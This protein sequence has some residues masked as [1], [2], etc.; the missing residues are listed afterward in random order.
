MREQTA[1]SLPYCLTTCNG[2][3]HCG[4]GVPPERR[5]CFERADRFV[6]GVLLGRLGG[7]ASPR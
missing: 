1:P 3:G 2:C 5:A 4:A 7:V 6:D